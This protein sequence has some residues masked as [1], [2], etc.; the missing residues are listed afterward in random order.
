MRNTETVRIYRPSQTGGGYGEA[1]ET[2]ALIATVQA[3]VVQVGGNLRGGQDDQLVRA[4]TDE[5]RVRWQIIMAPLDVEVFT[6]DRAKVRRAGSTHVYHV[7]SVYK[8]VRHWTLWAEEYTRERG[9]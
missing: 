5:T 2:E 8:D 9:I 1:V 7:Q 3:R 6:R 4:E